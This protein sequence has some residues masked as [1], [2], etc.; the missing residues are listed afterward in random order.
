MPFKKISFVGLVTV[1][2][3]FITSSINW[4]YPKNQYEKVVKAH[5]VLP[6]E[7]ETDLF[8]FTIENP[9]YSHQTL[10]KLRGVGRRILD[11]VVVKGDTKVFGYLKVIYSQL[12]NTEVQ[13]RAWI[14]HSIIKGFTSIYGKTDITNTELYNLTVK[15][16]FSISN[17][18]AKGALDVEGKFE[19]INTT[20]EDKVNILGLFKTRNSIFRKEVDIVGKVDALQ[21]C[22]KN[23]ITIISEKTLLKDVISKSICVKKSDCNKKCCRE[24]IQCKQCNN[25]QIITL[26][27]KTVIQGSITFESENGIVLL[28]EEATIEGQVIG[29]TIKKVVNSKK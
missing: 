9:D 13:G 29:G 7:E 1:F 28:E 25:S 18:T 20:F 24:N 2:F 11:H 14:S 4:S 21:T 19:A 26:A 12:N 8:L 17:S 15:G 5:E 6:T 16:R 10:K 27:G 3:S 22:F 23:T